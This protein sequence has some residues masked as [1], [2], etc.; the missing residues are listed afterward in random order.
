MKSI[1][2]SHIFDIIKKPDIL[3]L[4]KLIKRDFMKKIIALLIVVFV[5]SNA[6]AA[7][8]QDNCDRS[9]GLWLGKFSY[10]DPSFCQLSNPELCDKV[11]IAIGVKHL[12]EE[13]RYSADLYPQ[14]GVAATINLSCVDG[15]LTPLPNDPGLPPETK[16]AFQCD[17]LDNCTVS[18]EDFRLKALLIKMWQEDIRM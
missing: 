5:N 14:R 4:K 18:Y 16:I 8:S 3:M 12:D 10:K 15:N 13:N 2:P 9:Q 17:E 11:S 1:T 7:I 6:F